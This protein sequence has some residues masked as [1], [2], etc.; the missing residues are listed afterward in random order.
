MSQK[1]KNNP[2][3]VMEYYDWV[4]T[5]GFK[6]SEEHHQYVPYQEQDFLQKIIYP[7]FYDYSIQRKTC[8]PFPMVLK[9]HNSSTPIYVIDNNYFTIIFFSYDNY[10]DEKSWE[11]SIHIKDHNFCDKRINEFKTWYRKHYKRLFAEMETMP[12]EFLY[13]KL[14]LYGEEVQ[15][16]CIEFWNETRD[17]MLF[18]IMDLLRLF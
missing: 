18:K 9:D 3:N 12:K 14:E 16:F 7:M 10:D 8:V 11:V 2:L 1:K 13:P 15:D 4:A 17:F 5:Q 6:N